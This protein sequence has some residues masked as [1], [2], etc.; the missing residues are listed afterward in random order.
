[1]PGRAHELLSGNL[2]VSGCVCRRAC[3]EH[4]TCVLSAFPPGRLRAFHTCSSLFQQIRVPHS[5]RSAYRARSRRRRAIC[6]LLIHQHKLPQDVPDYL[7]RASS[8]Y[9]PTELQPSS[10]KAV[11]A[12]TFPFGGTEFRGRSL[13]D[14]CFGVNLEFNI[15]VGSHA[16]ALPDVVRRGDLP[17]LLQLSYFK[18]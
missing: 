2:K 15:G 8:T 17:W 10:T 9:L 6:E 3:D 11:P 1:M 7:P 5:S 16:E 14:D 12:A 4:A 13:E 18:V